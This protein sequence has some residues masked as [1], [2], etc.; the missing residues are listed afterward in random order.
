[1]SLRHQST[2]NDNKPSSTSSSSSQADY[3]K[4]FEDLLGSSKASE[5]EKS[6]ISEQA[7]VKRQHDA[8]HQKKF[9]QQKEEFEKRKQQDFDDLLSGKKRTDDMSL[10]EL[11][12]V[13][14]HKAKQ[15][16][17]KEGINTAKSSL[18]SFSSLLEKRRQKAQ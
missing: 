6:T 3:E 1:M 17:I 7:K 14:Y 4:S 11:F 2:K 8:E 5:Q 12:K 13:Y 15:T 16:D 18:N 10:Q 9:E